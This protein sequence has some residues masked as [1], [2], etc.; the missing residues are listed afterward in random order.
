MNNTN[1]GDYLHPRR[2]D[3]RHK[4][5]YV[6]TKISYGSICA[7]LDVG[8][9]DRVISLVIQDKQMTA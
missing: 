8:R 7:V 4:R 9:G 5:G 1:K 3:G 6:R 2:L